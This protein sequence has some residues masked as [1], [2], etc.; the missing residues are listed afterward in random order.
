MEQPRNAAASGG[1]NDFGALF[2]QSMRA[3]R[4]GDVVCGRVVT[5]SR[6][7]VTVDIGFKSEGQIPIQEFLDRAGNVDVHAGDEIDV[8]FDGT[9]SEH[10][11]PRLRALHLHLL[12]PA[13][14]APLGK[15]RGCPVHRLWQAPG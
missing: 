5:V 13:E 11:L 12:P 3:V 9:D 10:F 4:P 7:F 14:P 2:E 6:D 15:G 8:Y 1:E